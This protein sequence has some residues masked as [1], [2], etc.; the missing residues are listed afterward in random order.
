MDGG[1]QIVFELTAHMGDESMPIGRVALSAACFG[2]DEPAMTEI[3]GHMG[4]ALAMVGATACVAIQHGLCS[5]VDGKA[6]GVAMESVRMRG[7]RV[8]RDGEEG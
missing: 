1:E 7:G 3:D 5:V 6:E 8:L 4:K 2:G